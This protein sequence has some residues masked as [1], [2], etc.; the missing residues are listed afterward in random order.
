VLT[1]EMAAIVFSVT[2]CSKE[3]LHSSQ[4]RLDPLPFTEDYFVV[5]TGAVVVGVN[6]YINHARTLG[7]NSVATGDYSP[8]G[9]PNIQ[10]TTPSALPAAP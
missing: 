2:H 9:T 7:L 6:P 10:H 3:N 1:I 5:Y 8:K 4:L